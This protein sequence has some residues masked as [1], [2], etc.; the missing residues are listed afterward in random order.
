MV[1]DFPGIENAMQMRYRCLAASQINYILGDTGRSFVVG[2]GENY[3]KA[4]HTRDGLCAIDM[5]K[6]DCTYDRWSQKT[7]SPQVCVG[8]MVAGPTLTDSYED[9][10]ENYR[11][12]EIAIDV[13]AGFVSVLTAALTMPAEFWHN[14]SLTELE[15]YCD[16]VGYKHYNW[17]S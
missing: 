7:I 4:P 2:V 11:S 15:A 16:V 6:G 13:Q 1:A 14:G 5:E 8:A 3:P 9:T 10:R 17:D 12:T